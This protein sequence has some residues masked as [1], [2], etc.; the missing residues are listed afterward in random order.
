MQ[1]AE[2]LT[3]PRILDP[4]PIAEGGLKEG[5][6]SHD[7][8]AHELGRSSDRTVDMAFSRQMHHRIRFEAREQLV[9]KVPIADIP[10]DKAVMIA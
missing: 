7:V 5:M 1:K 2:R 9:E 4:L 8:G 10:M 6:S 3:P